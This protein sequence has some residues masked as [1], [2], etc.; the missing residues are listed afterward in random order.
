M[1]IGVTGHQ[2]LA[3]PDAW[4]WVRVQIDRIIEHTP[5]PVVG[6][7]SLALGADQIFAESVLEHGGALEAV[8]P[9]PEYED[10]FAGQHEREVYR[11]LLGR[12]VHR[13]V[14]PRA[15]SDEESYYAAGRFIVDSADLLLA[16]WDGEP[17]K[18]LG[19]TGDVV[20][21]AERARKP[22]VHVDP[23]KRRVE[24]RH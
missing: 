8:I 1:R 16:V 14:L 11:R 10:R 21:Y 5:P 2:H 17:A 20:R 13:I 12:A 3:Q 19:G 18:G 24:T 7:S 4:H 23:I 22:V 6:L 15:G 9:F